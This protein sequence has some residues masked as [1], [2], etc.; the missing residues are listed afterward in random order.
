[1]RRLALLSIL[2]LYHEDPT[3]FDNLTIPLE[4]TPSDTVEYIDSFRPDKA[5][6]VAGI[7]EK[8]AELEVIYPDPEA[9]KEA[10]GYWSRRQFHI[11][12][13]FLD[14]FLYKYNPI[15]N[16]DGTTTRTGSISDSGS[17]SETEGYSRSGTHSGETDTNT[18]AAFNSS[19]WEN[20]DKSVKTYDNPWTEE[21]ERGR[22]RSDESSRK[23]TETERRT[24]NIG[25]TMTQQMIKAEREL[26]DINYYDI[27]IED[28]K[29]NF[30][31]MVY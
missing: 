8:C 4:P 10:I 25:V 26:L 9:M 28:F 6:V 20:A 3:I 24:G 14:T 29:R 11:W 27:I 31:L 17:G 15:W 18:T 7:L 22:E 16:V 13:R 2:A 12:Q 23:S 21:E 30:C 1:M 5:V 19:A